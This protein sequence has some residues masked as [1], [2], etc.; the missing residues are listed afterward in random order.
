M[1]LCENLLSLTKKAEGAKEIKLFY[2]KFFAAQAKNRCVFAR[3]F[4]SGKIVSYK[5]LPVKRIAVMQQIHEIPP[6]PF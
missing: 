1:R 4:Y 3:T 6:C 2:K 5:K